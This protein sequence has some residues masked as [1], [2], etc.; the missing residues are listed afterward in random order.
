[1]GKIIFELLTPILLVL[2]GIVD[3]VIPSFS[4]KEYFWYAKSIFKSEP[5]KSF[6]QE[7][8]DAQKAY[9]DAK[10][11]ME[12]LKNSA[13]EETED[14]KERLEKSEKA[15]LNAKEKLDKLKK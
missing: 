3:I 10:S 2:Y 7:V 8:K 1:M 13:N 5:Q 15:F 14:A 9:K 4:S 11:K 6:D 12:D